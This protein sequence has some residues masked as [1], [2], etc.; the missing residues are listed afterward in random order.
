M[1]YVQ[2]VAGMLR[3]V[4]I[5]RRCEVCDMDS[6]HGALHRKPVNLVAGFLRERE[7]FMSA[8]VNARR[9]RA[10][11][12]VTASLAMGVSVALGTDSAAAA[13]TDPD[14]GGPTTNVVGG[15][16]AA[17]GEFPWMVH[18]SMGCGGSL[19]TNQIVLTAAHCVG[20]TGADTSITAFVGS[21]DLND[22]NGVEV[23][24]TYVY[25]GPDSG[26]QVA[27]WALIKLAAPVDLPTLPL[28]TT[29]DFDTGT[30]TIAGWGA[31]SEGGGGSDALLKADVP[32]VDDAQCGQ[33]YPELVAD[34]EICAGDWDNGGVDT[35]QGDSG[36]PMFRPDGTGAWIQ[37]GIVSWGNG[38][39]RPQNPGVYTQVS[40]FADEIQA[41]AAGL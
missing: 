1:T 32:F 4:A 40:F 20:G 16:P 39:A 17:D 11:L 13:P 10:L 34:E 12:G 8:H 24:S 23:G 37:I 15:V 33:A 5:G 38:C 18:L 2:H 6:W 27:D 14:V 26:G 25:S 36:G 9:R 21:N 7:Y 31:T 35:C 3:S 28:A 30:F 41:A 19:L 22:P 29:A